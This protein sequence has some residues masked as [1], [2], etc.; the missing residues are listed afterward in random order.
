MV[1]RVAE[2]QMCFQHNVLCVQEVSELSLDNLTVL[3]VKTMIW[4]LI[5]VRTLENPTSFTPVR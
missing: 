1:W 3:E 5:V 2:G 4:A